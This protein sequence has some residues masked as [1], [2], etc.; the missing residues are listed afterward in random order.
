MLDLWQE[1][2]F[3]GREDV[4]CSSENVAL[5]REAVAALAQRTGG[6]VSRH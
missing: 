5:L 1:R 2:S 3:D 4:P 6:T